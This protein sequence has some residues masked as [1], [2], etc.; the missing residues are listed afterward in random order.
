MKKI[1]A[2]VLTFTVFTG[3]F[4]VADLAQKNNPNEVRPQNPP[5]IINRIQPPKIVEYTVEEARDKITEEDCRTI[6]NYLCSQELEGRMSGHPGNDKAAEYIAKH[7]KDC[8]L[9]PAV[10]GSYFQS[11][12]VDNVNDYRRDGTGKTANVIGYLPGN[13]PV[14][15]DEV[16][17]IG[18]H[19][20]HIGYGPSY[21]STPNRREVHPGAD[22]NAS[23]TTLVMEAAK[24]ASYLKGKNKR[25]IVFICF[26]GEEMG[27]IGATYYCNHPVFPLQSTRIMVNQD[28]VGRYREKGTLVC[29]GAGR[30]Q[31]ATAVIRKIENQ[32]PFK[33]LINSDS[34]GGS[35]HASF[36]RRGVNTCMFHTGQH[37][38][39]HT[40]EDKPSLI[41]FK[42]MTL[43]SRFVFH[44]T[45]EMAN[46]Q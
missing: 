12:T 46:Y 22:D 32:Y 42:G 26:S 37:D 27:L 8:G 25:T 13:D 24:A 30:S 45:W 18:A 3:L 17:I 7:F 11:F 23:G 35:D 2:F 44:L 6:L 28:M 21:S 16:I 5:P 9:Q 39:Y 40:P 33:C 31:L 41:D 20:D 19:F 36:I 15:K 29:G 1:L 43:I 14:L 4:F 34:G 38:Q 10:N